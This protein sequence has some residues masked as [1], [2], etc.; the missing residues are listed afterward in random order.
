MKAKHYLLA[1]LLIILIVVLR[2]IASS[3]DSK[4]QDKIQNTISK[5][6]EEQ[7]LDLS[8]ENYKFNPLFLNLE[9]NKIKIKH[10]DYA[11]EAKTLN[12]ALAPL[13]LLFG[14]LKVSEIAIRDST[15]SVFNVKNSKK[16]IDWKTVDLSELQK[17]IQEDVFSP[18]KEFVDKNSLNISKAI[19]YNFKIQ[20][21]DFN[22]AFEQLNLK[23]LSNHSIFVQGDFDF[24]RLSVPVSSWQGDVSFFIHDQ[25]NDSLLDINHIE[26]KN[27]KIDLVLKAAG[28]LPGIL[29]G[30]LSLMLDNLK[31]EAS[32][33]PLLGEN[34]DSFKWRGRSQNK[35]KIKTAKRRSKN[36]ELNFELVD[37]KRSPVEESAKPLKR[38]LSLKRLKGVLKSDDLD[39]KKFKI[40]NLMA[41]LPKGPGSSEDWKNS[42]SLKEIQIDYKQNFFKSTVALQEASLCS[43]LYSSGVG[44]CFSKAKM[45]GTIDLSGTLQ[46]LKL[47]AV[48]DLE[49]ND[50]QVSTQTFDKS[51]D[52]LVT[53]QSFKLKGKALAFAKK[54]KVTKL[55]AI[56]PGGE[57]LD[58]SG[59]V[60]YIP[61]RVEL[62]CV[63]STLDL[64]KMLDNFLKQRISGRAKVRSHVSYFSR[65]KEINR[66]KVTSQLFI[67][68][69]KWQSAELGDLKG[70]INY[71]NRELFF[72]S[73]KLK[74]GGGFADIGGRI[75]RDN[76][77]KSAIDLKSKLNN[78]YLNILTH[79]EAKTA[80]Y[81]GYMSGV[82]DLQGAFSDQKLRGRF[83]LGLKD[84]LI[85]DI[86][87]EKGSLKAN[88]LKSV[89]EI[90]RLKAFREQGF[91]LAKGKLSKE[92]SRIDFESAKVDLSKL[93]IL[94]ELKIFTNATG[95]VKGFWQ[96]DLG[97]RVKISKLMAKIYGRPV[98][99]GVVEVG[100]NRKSQLEVL[101]DFPALAEFNLKYLL[102][103]EKN[104]I[105]HFAADLADEGIFMAL[106]YWNQ[107][108]EL[109]GL[110]TRGRV[111]YEWKPGAG[112]IELENLLIK[113]KQAKD[114]LKSTKKTY[115]SWNAST[116][117]KN[118]MN[119]EGPCLIDKEKDLLSKNFFY[120]I[121]CSM[122]FINLVIPNLQF[123]SG[124]LKGRGYVKFPVTFKN[125]NFEGSMNNS[126][127]L[128]P[129]LQNAMQDIQVDILYQKKLLSMSNG[130]AKMGEGKVLFQGTYN[131][132]GRK[133]KVSLLVN[134]KDVRNAL[135]G[136]ISALLDGEVKI[137]NHKPY[138]I[139]GDV[140]IKEG[141]YAAEFNSDKNVL[142]KVE[143]ALFDFNLSVNVSKEY[144]LN[145]STMDA[146]LGGSML[147][148][149]SELKPLFNGEL[150]FK[151]GG[152]VFVAEHPF[153]VVGGQ[154]LFS[155]KE[156]QKISVNLEARY[157]MELNQQKYD[158]QLNVSGYSDDLNFDFSSVPSLESKDILNMLA[159]GVVPGSDADDGIAAENIALQ[160][161]FNNLIA[162]TLQNKAGVRVQIENSQG[163]N[164][165]DERSPK[166]TLHRKISDRV[167]AVIGSSL[168]IDKPN[169]DYRIDY[170]I[171][172]NIDLSGGVETSA[173]EE[174]SF[175]F[176]LKF[177]FD[178]N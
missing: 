131:I 49:V 85:Y 63:S 58:I 160:L 15:A 77:G 79:K 175:G 71:N 156:E 54:A 43:L 36:M 9:V 115:L 64:A 102:Q 98:V 55:K 83:D 141:L 38:Q 88:Y 154:V 1:L 111:K 110:I 51:D 24:S 134:M 48:L 80:L 103:K 130:R 133:P 116:M 144:V 95:A 76:N 42:Y 53:L 50:A 74:K 78:I 67:Q 70:E 68:N 94:P 147:L 99:D 142:S 143:Q 122:D 31:K 140:L 52:L 148:R 173:D 5:L 45:Q 37:F 18:L 174:A 161:L 75:Y 118:D 8:Y 81:K 40:Q 172:D 138:L 20:S 170:N 69:L 28:S 176:D 132:Q 150:I 114:L 107:W 35:F 73:L 34:R 92:K 60:E 149:G 91:L 153:V 90:K 3:L 22:F 120:K 123:S 29:E 121:D 135:E 62:D 119:L 27:N 165:G 61:T 10:V 177:K 82:V 101:L 106:A 32:L 171:Y 152:K 100:G 72:S 59:F 159:F 7:D 117:V 46:P 105:L 139:V 17:Q 86:P 21:K 158:L 109:P 155:D 146:A 16:K 93:Y 89:F 56:W 137:L 164:D 157:S 167:T 104:K 126:E 124:R 6:S 84:F 178:I 19:F 44:E 33:A 12:I 57:S 23:N 151:K 11:L 162:K 65:R 26:L 113:N 96:S 127:L 39:F 129:K 168:D 108:Q 4:L 30:D 163:L 166:V 125:I 128:F 112:F 136:N 145:N 87:F 25:Q 66:T 2:P 13:S 14:R 97:W 47:N 169:R 41:I